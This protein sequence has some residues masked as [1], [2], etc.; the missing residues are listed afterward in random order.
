MGRLQVWLHSRAG[1]ITGSTEPMWKFMSIGKSPA[2]N[3]DIEETLERWGA[4]CTLHTEN[5]LKALSNL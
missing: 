5:M 4:T 3:K 1:N 2:S